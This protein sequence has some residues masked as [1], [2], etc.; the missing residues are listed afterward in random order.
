MEVLSWILAMSGLIASVIGIWF[1]Y[2]TYTSP[3]IRFK[4]YLKRKDNWKMIF[5]RVKGISDYHQYSKHPEFTLEEVY[6][7]RWERDEPWMKKVIRPDPACHASQIALKV[8]GN[9]VHTENF[10]SMDGGRITVPIPKLDTK[11]QDKEEKFV[12]YYDEIQ[13]LLAGLLGKY[14]IYDSLEDFCKDK[15]RL[16]YNPQ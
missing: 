4:W 3:M 13:I 6:D 1:S 5:P 12:Y 10:I 8:N 2:I 16:D 7:R 14:H 11:G 9:I 15:I